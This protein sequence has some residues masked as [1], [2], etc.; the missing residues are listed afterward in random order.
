MEDLLLNSFIFFLFAG[1]F[2]YSIGLAT[3]PKAP[4]MPGAS[5]VMGHKPDPLNWN[6][7]KEGKAWHKWN[8]TF[9]KLA[10]YWLYIM[11]VH[12]AIFFIMFLYIG[13]S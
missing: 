3:E 1:M 10:K 2:G 11:L 12:G 4:N 7:S 8:N 6:N 5:K 9:N 13:L